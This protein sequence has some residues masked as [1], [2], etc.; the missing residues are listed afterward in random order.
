V[1]IREPQG[2]C[3]RAAPLPTNGIRQRSCSREDAFARRLGNDRPPAQS[4]L[5]KHGEIAPYCRPA[6]IGR[7]GSPQLVRL[8]LGER[9][10]R[11]DHIELD[12]P[13]GAACLPDPRL[14]CE[15]RLPSSPTRCVTKA[16]TSRIGCVELSRARVPGDE[17]L[18][19]RHASSPSCWS[20]GFAANL[21]LLEGSAR[22]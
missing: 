15:L 2:R 19:Q 7:S 11:S 12:H 22:P 3:S 18:A 4:P 21:A 5:E 14:S 13:E 6:C 16:R 10:Q 1:A 20:G 9:D 8:T 17:R